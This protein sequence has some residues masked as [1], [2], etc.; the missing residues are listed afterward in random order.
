MPGKGMH[1][2]GDVARERL[3]LER[4]CL[5]QDAE[6]CA[7]LNFCF[8][9]EWFLTKGPIHIYTSLPP[10]VAICCRS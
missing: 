4:A 9:G 10:D 5:P 8:P 6:D 1:Q 3:Q 2:L 7:V